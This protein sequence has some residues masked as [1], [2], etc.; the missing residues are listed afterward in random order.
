VRR[1]VNVVLLSVARKFLVADKAGTLPTCVAPPYDWKFRSHLKAETLVA[2]YQFFTGLEGSGSGKRLDLRLL[3]FRKLPLKVIHR[4]IR[5]TH[6][7]AR[8]I[9][10]FQ[11][12]QY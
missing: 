11:I 6:W 5:M 10:R 4:H 2:L 1:L 8:R 3:L 9:G 12:S 7:A